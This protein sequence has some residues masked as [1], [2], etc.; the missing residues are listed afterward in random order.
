[1][2]ACRV[3]GASLMLLALLAL[4]SAARACQ[5]AGDAGGEAAT[6]APDARPVLERVWAHWGALREVGVTATTS[7]SFG[8]EGQVENPGGAMALVAARPNRISIRPAGDDTDG[9]YLVSDGERLIQYVGG[10]RKYEQ[11]EA[12]GTFAGLA[13]AACFG[14]A[15]EAQMILMQRHLF[16]LA[17]L[18]GEMFKGVCDKA[19]KIEYV[20]RE[21]LD[22]RACDRVRLSTEQIAVDLWVRA[23]G[24]AWIDRVVPDMSKIL[25]GLG[26]AG[27]EL[28]ER[29]PQMAVSFGDWTDRPGIEGAFTFAPPEGAERVAS[30]RDALQAQMADAGGD[31]GADHDD[32]LGKPAPELDLD[33]LDGGKASLAAHRGKDVVLLDFWAT[34]CPPCVRGLPVV[35][36]V[37]AGFKDKGVVFYAVNEQETP[38]AI[39]KFLEKKQ[40]DIKVALDA[41]GAAGRDFG[42]R[43]IPQTV[44]IGRDGTVQSVHVGFS[45]DLKEELTRQ[46]QAL[47]DGKPLHVPDGPEKP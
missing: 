28:K 39:R 19:E 34:W 8:G 18:D 35:S 32:L 16:V 27:E 2:V 41:E 38:D 21:E 42:V 33:L 25:A 30:L 10:F 23:E 12:P 7:M 13:E 3:F 36:D 45:P 46:L 22:G 5:P 24:P 15:P 6:G 1:M 9:Y 40:L 26:A 47:V 20:G 37:A 43:G 31:E 17:L 29:M 4:G 14:A 11:A 44:L